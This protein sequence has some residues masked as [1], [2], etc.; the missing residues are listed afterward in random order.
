MVKI[1]SPFVHLIAIHLTDCFQE[2]VFSLSHLHICVD[3]CVTLVR[4]EMRKL[5][6]GIIMAVKLKATSA[7][8][9]LGV[10]SHFNSKCI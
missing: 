10:L 6:L 4:V 1:K 7:F 5:Y 8:M 2:G 3:T 9:I